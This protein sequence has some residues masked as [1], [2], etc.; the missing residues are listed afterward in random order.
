MFCSHIPQTSYA[1]VYFI[2]CCDLILKLSMCTATSS[3]RPMHILYV[4]KAKPTHYCLQAFPSN[5]FQHW[6]YVSSQNSSLVG[7]EPTTSGLEVRRA[8][9]CATET[10]VQFWP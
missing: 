9:H 5:Y 1:L 6:E 7:L 4:T 3:L 10:A 2:H 8:I